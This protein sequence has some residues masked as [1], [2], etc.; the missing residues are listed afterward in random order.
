MDGWCL[1]DLVGI[2]TVRK[3]DAVNILA[4]IFKDEKKGEI[5]KLLMGIK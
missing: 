3:K 4:S 5:M 1:Q 2:S